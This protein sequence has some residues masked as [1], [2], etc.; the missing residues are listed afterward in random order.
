MTPFVAYKVC[1]HDLYDATVEKNILPALFLSMVTNS[2]THARDRDGVR[3]I[4]THQT[5]VASHE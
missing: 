1:D 3:R 4:D 5:A 2:L